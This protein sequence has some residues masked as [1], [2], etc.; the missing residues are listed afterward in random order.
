MRIEECKGGSVV[1][2]RGVISRVRKK[3]GGKNAIIGEGRPTNVG[4]TILLGAS[5]FPPGS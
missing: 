3:N 1:N 5:C 4:T 2:V